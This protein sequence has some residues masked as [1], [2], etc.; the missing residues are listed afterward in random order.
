MG[1]LIVL[2]SAAAL[3]NAEHDNTHFLLQGD[4]GSLVLVDCGS[5]PVIK[6]PRYGIH[7]ADLP[8]IVVTHFHP[9]H[10]SGIP[11]MLMQ[12]WLL[13]RQL[14]LRLLGLHHCLSRIET[15]I[16]ACQ[17]RTWPGFFPL[18]FHPL[19]E[20]PGTL[21][22]D[23][24]DFRIRAWP[25]RHFIPTI[26]LRI[27]VKA[28]GQIISYSCDTEPVPNIVTLAQDADLLLHE[29]AGAGYGHSSAAQAG[30]T[31][32]AA[33][34][35]RLVLIH[36]NVWEHDPG[37]LVD[38]ARTTFSGPVELAEDFKEYSI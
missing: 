24:I 12:M 26:G 17:W 7:P 32:T 6:L 5:N 9:D 33:G 14:P 22:L 20:Q 11:I 1:R 2:G 15:M 37:P 36:Y 34:A 13:G 29:A 18:E 35:R 3:S 27:E 38:E 10:V 30:E 23:N 4:Y 8:D 19:P 25:T 31:A 21:V 16:E 28:S